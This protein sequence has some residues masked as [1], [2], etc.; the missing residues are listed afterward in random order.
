MYL[1]EAPEVQGGNVTCP[2][3]KWVGHA[4]CRGSCLTYRELQELPDAHF[5]SPTPEPHLGRSQYPHRRLLLN[6]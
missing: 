4:L 3:G 5:P 1:A 6:F 2:L